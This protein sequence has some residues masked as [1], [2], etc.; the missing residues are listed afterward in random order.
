[1]LICPSFFYR[2]KIYTESFILV[3][4]YLK[5]SIK[6]KVEHTHTHIHT[7]IYSREIHRG[8]V[9]F[10]RSKGKSLIRIVILQLPTSTDIFVAN[11]NT[12]AG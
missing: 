1:M 11:N 2:P 12:I 6:R 10:H 5:C 9:T 4:Y 3:Q 7:Y 8:G